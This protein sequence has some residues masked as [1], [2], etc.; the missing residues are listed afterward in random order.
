MALEAFPGS[1]HTAGT[2]AV[3]GTHQQVYSPAERL[4]QCAAADSELRLAVVKRDLSNAT[5][6]LTE[7]K[8]LAADFEAQ[9]NVVL[10]G[11]VAAEGIATLCNQRCQEAEERARQADLVAMN[12]D[13]Q[14]AIVESNLI[15]QDEAV[16]E[17]EREC[18]RSHLR[19]QQEV[20]RRIAAE[21]RATVAEGQLGSLH[22]RV[23]QLAKEV[24]QAEV[25]SQ[26][27]I[28]VAEQMAES[29]V[30][31]ADL[32]VTRAEARSHASEATASQVIAEFRRQRGAS[33]PASP[34][35]STSPT[36]RSPGGLRLGN[37][38]NSPT[39]NGAS[40][41][42]RN[43]FSQQAAAAEAALLSQRQQA[44]SG[45]PVSP[46]FF[47][48]QRASLGSPRASPFGVPVQQPQPP[49]QAT[50]GDVTPP[51]SFRQSSPSR[52]QFGAPMQQP[53]A[54]QQALGGGVTPPSR[55][56]SSPSR[57][58]QQAVSGG[59]TTPSR[60]QSSPN[61][62]PT[63]GSAATSTAPTLPLAARTGGLV[64]VPVT[65]VKPGGRVSLASTACSSFAGAGGTDAPAPVSSDMSASSINYIDIVPDARGPGGM[66]RISPPAT[67]TAASSTGASTPSRTAGSATVGS[68]T[69]LAGS[70]GS[71]GASTPRGTPV[72]AGT[73]TSMGKAAPE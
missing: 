42:S 37:G 58:Q 52:R 19:Y 45:S 48:G 56:Q 62:R 67:A 36:R 35:K 31:E 10:T 47:P 2:P 73:P 61:R 28:R 14:A 51:P 20:E 38:G 13:A 3:Y 44:S 1:Y 21:T 55:R 32:K 68:A 16:Q 24:A 25:R 71:T 41:P 39:R 12:K 27:R 50:G 49:Q 63:A 66:L 60:R 53:Q 43:S 65:S 72:C 9:L 6:Q 23:A 64:H 8:K 4:A 7:S 33:P 54:P 26:D 11:K 59:V 34:R 57:Q 5:A 40:S 46:R 15:M 70:A 17:R 18:E 30:R 69:L 29:R 22:A